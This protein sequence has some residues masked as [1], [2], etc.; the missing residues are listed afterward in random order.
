M[1]REEATEAALARFLPLM[2]QLR[3]H[4][5]SPEDFASR[6][7]R[8][9]AAGYRLLG[10]RE[11]GDFV[12]L[13]GIRPMET[14]IHGPFL[15]VD[16]LVTREEARSRGVGSHVMADLKR[17]ARAMG[18]A[19]LVLDTALDNVL[20]HRFYYRQGLLAMALRFNVPLA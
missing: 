19:K 20:G 5:G 4:L 2:R 12:A 10:Y 14:L 16:D 8:M 7:R 3:P 1:H 18:C 17:E 6:F 9:S 11:E 13:A 15:Y